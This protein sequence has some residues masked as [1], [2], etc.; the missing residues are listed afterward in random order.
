MLITPVLALLP[1]SPC[2]VIPKPGRA[3]MGEMAINGTPGIIFWVL[4]RGRGNGVRPG[5]AS[6]SKHPDQ[7]MVTQRMLG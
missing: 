5:R 7:A 6:Y 4:S 2:S 1:T 3:R